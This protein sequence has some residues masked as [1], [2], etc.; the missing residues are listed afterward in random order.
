MHGD[1][2]VSISG[3]RAADSLAHPFHSE[4][5][6]LGGHLRRRV[7]I[8]Q[9]HRQQW[10]AVRVN[11]HHPGPPENRFGLRKAQRSIAVCG[12]VDAH[13]H[14]TVDRG[15]GRRHHDRGAQGARRDA[16]TH[17]PQRHRTQSAETARADDDQGGIA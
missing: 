17:R 7:R 10:D 13:Y 5:T 3:P 16:A 4:S 1:L 9:R 2:D 15:G 11:R 14:R 8:D 12:S 6:L